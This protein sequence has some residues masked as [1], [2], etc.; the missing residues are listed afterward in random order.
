MDIINHGKIGKMMWKGGWKWIYSSSAWVTR[1]V[2]LVK[3]C[4]RRSQAGPKRERGWGGISCTRILGW[5]TYR[6]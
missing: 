1:L 2:R 3:G 4:E 6:V 5:Q